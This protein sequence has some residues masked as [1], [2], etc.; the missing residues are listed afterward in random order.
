[1][2]VVRIHQ[3]IGP[4][5]R[6]RSRG[7]GDVTC[8]RPRCVGAA[9]QKLARGMAAPSRRQ[10]RRAFRILKL[11]L[12]IWIL[13]ALMAE[14][15]ATMVRLGLMDGHI[16]EPRGSHD[17]PRVRKLREASDLSLSG[18]TQLGYYYALVHLVRNPCVACTGSVRGQSRLCRELRAADLRGKRP[19][20]H[21][22]R[23]S[24]H[25]YLSPNK[26]NAHLLSAHPCSALRSRAAG[27]SLCDE[28][29]RHALAGLPAEVLHD[30]RRHRQHAALRALL[31]L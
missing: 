31:H 19:G 11:A 4:A 14:C 24:M 21:R 26:S 25:G 9:D 20:R 5:R 17:H 7:D 30:N 13:R 8:A 6:R 10:P 28:Q 27:T 16:R 2:L 23:P 12:S 3:L 18:S 1:L 22:V 29:A 15:E